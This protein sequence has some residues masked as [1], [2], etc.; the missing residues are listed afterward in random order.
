MKKTGRLFNGINILLLFT[1]YMFNQVD[2]SR[3]TEPEQRIHLPPT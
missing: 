1:A 3:F 2:I